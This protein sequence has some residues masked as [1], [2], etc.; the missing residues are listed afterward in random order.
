MGRWGCGG[1]WEGSARAEGDGSWGRCRGRERPPGGGKHSLSCT[2]KAL[3]V[4]GGERHVR[5]SREL[6]PL[7]RPGQMCFP[8]SASPRGLCHVALRGLHPPRR[9]GAGWGAAG[10]EG[11]LRDVG[12]GSAHRPCPALGGAL[13][14]CFP[15]VGELLPRELPA[16]PGTTAGRAQ[17][18]PAL[19]PATRVPSRRGAQT[20][21]PAAGH[22]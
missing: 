13:R 10:A 19:P 3:R 12:L 4:P 18:P 11:K 15:G 21:A 1:R 22:A 6:E 9:P 14:G 8:D 17:S 16:G 5:G 7:R 2:L 20:A